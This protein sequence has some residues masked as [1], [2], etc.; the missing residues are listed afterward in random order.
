M[1]VLLWFFAIIGFLVVALILYAILVP[2]KPPSYSS[3]AD[4]DWERYRDKCTGNYDEV[5]DRPIK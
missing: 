4:G 5:N 3:G 1:T 2:T